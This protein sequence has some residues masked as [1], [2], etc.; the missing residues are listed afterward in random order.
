MLLLED[1]LRTCG[2]C[3]LWTVLLLACVWAY[4]QCTLV[5]R[6]YGGP[7]KV[8]R[9][10]RL[11]D[12]TG[13]ASKWRECVNECHTRATECPI[14]VSCLC[15]RPS[16]PHPVGMAQCHDT[17]VRIKPDDPMLDGFYLLLLPGLVV[18]CICQGWLQCPQSMWQ[19]QVQTPPSIFSMPGTG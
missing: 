13:A 17:D 12:S 8:L 15:D 5:W 7:M 11:V 19:Q 6:A 9:P 2:T 3:K 14:V 18:Q 16:V 1:P 4:C 10:Q